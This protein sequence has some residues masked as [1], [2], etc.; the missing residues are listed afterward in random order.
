ML[1]GAHAT[2]SDFCQQP[3]GFPTLTLLF[4]RARSAASAISGSLQ[5]HGL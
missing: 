2:W 4:V 1:S 5:P 3:L